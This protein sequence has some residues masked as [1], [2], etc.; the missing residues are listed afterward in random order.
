MLKEASVNVRHQQ[1]TLE[2][3]SR[4]PEEFTVEDLMKCFGVS[5]NA[6]TTRICRLSKDHLVE[7]IG[8]YKENGASKCKYRKTGVILL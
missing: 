5:H 8:E 4:L 7:K 1:K 2:S 6:A 3:F